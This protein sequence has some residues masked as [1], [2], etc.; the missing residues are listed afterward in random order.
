MFTYLDRHSFRRSR[1]RVARSGC[2]AGCP[3]LPAGTPR[4][5]A[6][7]C[8]PRHTLRTVPADCGYLHRQ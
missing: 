2:P 7:Q 8:G 5:Q 3:C 4:T 6:A 1:P